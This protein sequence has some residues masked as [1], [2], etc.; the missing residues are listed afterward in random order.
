MTVCDDP[1][2]TEGSNTEAKIKSLDQLAKERVGQ[3]IVPGDN[4]PGGAFVHIVSG[5]Y[6]SEE[7]AGG[8]ASIELAV[9]CHKD[10]HE[11]EYGGRNY[12]QTLTQALPSGRMVCPVC[13][14]AERLRLSHLAQME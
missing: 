8:S 12:C 11:G 4:N 14:E 7:T 10:I 2:G 6:W 5:V 13:A 9:H 3:Y 1:W